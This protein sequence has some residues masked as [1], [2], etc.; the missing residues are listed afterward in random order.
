MSRKIRVGISG[1]ALTPEGKPAMPGPALKFL[2][3]IPNAEHKFFPEHLKEVTA[4][5]IKGFDVVV[6]LIPAWTERTVAGNDQLLAIH[7]TGVGYDM[8]D[9]PAMTKANVLLTIT[10]DAVRRP[11]AVAIMTFLLALSTRI[12]IKDKIT[13]AGKGWEER[14]KY[15]GVGLVG[16]TFGS[17]GVGNIGHEAFK[18]AKPFGMKHI[19]YD[20]Y[21]KQSAVNDV[22][23]KLVDMDTVLS[24]SDF[25]NISCP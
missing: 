6:S 3:E 2:E 19:A 12:F 22:G 8:V 11:V 9:V 15:H 24:E 25:L 10:P 17:I 4:E 1:D 20:P 18:L 13:R 16:R 23:V 14:A 21:I 7:R 5:Q